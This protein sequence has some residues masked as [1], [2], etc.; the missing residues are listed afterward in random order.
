MKDEA[1]VHRR[2]HRDHSRSGRVLGGQG[3]DEALDGAE[4]DVDV[5]AGGF[6]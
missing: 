6:A 4:V 2:N 5:E 3:L 1:R